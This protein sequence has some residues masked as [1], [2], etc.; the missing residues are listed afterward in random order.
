MVKRENVFL[1]KLALQ[2][3]SFPFTPQD[4]NDYYSFL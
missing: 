1:D 3:W 4:N 2:K